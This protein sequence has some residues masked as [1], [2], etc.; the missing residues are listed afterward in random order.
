MKKAINTV[1]T[2][3]LLTGS[4]QLLAMNQNPENDA[5]NRLQQGHNVISQFNTDIKVEAPPIN[6]SR[7]HEIIN[8]LSAEN[9]ID[10]LNKANVHLSTNPNTAM[11]FI[12]NK[13]ALFNTM[14]KGLIQ[15]D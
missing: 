1:M 4:A 11:A 7:A 3:I 8:Q 13:Q 2:T 10:M 14:V 9:I 15:L 6:L 12:F 5:Q